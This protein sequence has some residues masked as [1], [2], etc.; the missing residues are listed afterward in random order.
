METVR[1]AFFG[2]GEVQEKSKG[3]VREMLKIL[4]KELKDKTFFVANEFGFADIVANMV[5][6]WLGVYQAVSGVELVTEEK[7]PI[8]CAWRDKYV[9]CSQ[10][11]EHLPSRDALIAFYQASARP[12]AAASASTPEIGIVIVP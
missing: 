8:F 10:V 11:K 7:F 2:K 3:E 12:Q 6:L 5:G 9:E 4:D 1:Y